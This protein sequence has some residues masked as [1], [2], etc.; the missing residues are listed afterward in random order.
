[1]GW[2]SIVQESQTA[3]SG[4]QRRLGLAGWGALLRR[5]LVSP[6]GPPE[7]PRGASWSSLAWLQPGE[8]LMALVVSGMSC[9]ASLAAAEQQQLLEP[10]A[11]Q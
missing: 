11:L 2:E 9:V 1:M 8:Y 6:S 7:P 4:S 10:T 5:V 3:L